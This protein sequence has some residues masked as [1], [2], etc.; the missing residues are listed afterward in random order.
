MSLAK[1]LARQSAAVAQFARLLEDELHQLA[2]GAVDGQRLTELA[3][4]K[5]SLLTEIEQLEAQR[6]NAQLRLGY[7]DD[8]QGAARA[9]ADAG[10]HNAWQQLLAQASRAQLLNRL[11]GE[12]IRMRLEHNQRMLNFL[13][14]AAGK[15]LYGPD[16]QSRQGRLGS[17]ASRA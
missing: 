1:H 12:S 4:A 11:N 3:A 14:E 10:C 5:Q 8:R 15:G 2:K 17:I 13:H 16:G 9:A 6:R 7:G